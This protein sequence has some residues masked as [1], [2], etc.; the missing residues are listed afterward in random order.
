M[1]NW[2]PDIIKLVEYLQTQSQNYGE[3]FIYNKKCGYMANEGGSYLFA[4]AD[5]KWGTKQSPWWEDSKPI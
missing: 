2:E 5:P 4:L 1:Y 3:D